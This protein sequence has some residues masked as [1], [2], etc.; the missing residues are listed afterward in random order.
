MKRTLAARALV[1][2][3]DT[4]PMTSANATRPTG[5][6]A[7]RG[8]RVFEIG[9]ADGF[10]GKISHAVLRGYCPCAGCQGHS[11]T[12]RFVSGGDEELL[13][14]VEVGNYALQL[15]WG[16]H[17]DSGLYSFRYLRLLSEVAADETAGERGT[18]VERR[19]LP[20]V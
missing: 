6:K 18:S 8:A 15:T 13:E 7:P 12:I 4:E 16:D 9:W 19:E 5:I 17:H 1:R 2:S 3:A 11:G 10:I 14:I 20:R